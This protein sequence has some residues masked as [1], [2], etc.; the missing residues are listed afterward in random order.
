MKV[1]V[2]GCGGSGGVPLI[3]GNWGDCD[4]AEPRNRRRRSS[5]LI[6]SSGTTVLVDASPDCRE[7][8]LDAGIDH[9]DAVVVTHA[10][11]DH[12]HG[13]DDLR[14]VNVAMGRAIPAYA[15]AVTLEQ[16]NTRFGYVFA[17][18]DSAANGHFYKPCLDPHP[19]DGPFRVGNLEIVPFAQDHGF[20]ATT[21]LRIDD[22]GYSIDVMRLGE[23][24]F[25][26]LDGV[27]DWIVDCLGRTPHPTHAHL[28]LSLEWIER[29]G[30]ARAWLS[31]MSVGLDYR[32]LLSELPDGVEPAYDGLCI[33][34]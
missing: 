9:L 31:H 13:I 6:E 2:L 18:L 14:W 11:A 1:T 17:P 20:S 26:A 29:V 34:L 19:I 10:H 16:I 33:E 27:S 7:Q 28:Q 3:G 21:G 4:P 22:F 24:A 30:P 32:A 23:D 25:A 8:L 12:I 15:T 5:I